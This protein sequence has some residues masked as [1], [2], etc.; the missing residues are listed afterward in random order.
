MKRWTIVAAWLALFWT[1]APVF[2]AGLIIVEDAHWRPGPMPPPFIPPR[3]FPPPRLY[4]FAPLDVDYVKVKTRITDQVAV[5]SVDQEFYNPNPA[6]LEG[7]FRVP[8][9]QR[10]AH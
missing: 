7:T 8:C 1:I 6:R 9:P 4:S 3:P 5:T 10:R 2:G